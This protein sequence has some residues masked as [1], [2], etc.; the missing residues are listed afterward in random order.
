MWPRTALAL[1][2][3]GTTARRPRHGRR[4]GSPPSSPRLQSRTGSWPVNSAH[5]RTPSSSPPVGGPY[6]TIAPD[7][8][9]R[10]VNRARHDARS[11]S[12]RDRS[13]RAIV[14]VVQGT[15]PRGASYP[16]SAAASLR[17]R[18]GPAR[19]HRNP[20][21]HT[22]RQSAPNRQQA[23]RITPAEGAL[24]GSGFPFAS[25]AGDG[26]LS[27]RFHDLRHTHATKAT[28]LLRAGVHIKVVAERLGDCCPRASHL[29]PCWLPSHASDCR[30]GPKWDGSLWFT[31]LTSPS[32]FGKSRKGL[33]GSSCTTPF[34]LV[35]A[36]IYPACP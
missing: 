12:Q 34:Q 9:A 33:L 7:A 3:R 28:E 17:V 19:E 29:G 1:R 18:F 25:Q 22:P 21:R 15:P 23:N 10:L 2:L 32:V 16:V 20:V 26:L 36:S 6:Q 27:G 31:A 11:S 14:A 5:A 8:R 13:S 30:G 4:G 35:D 24:S